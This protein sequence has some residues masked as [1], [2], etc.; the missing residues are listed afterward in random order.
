MV[1]RHQLLSQHSF[2][3]ILYLTPPVFMLDLI[4]KGSLMGQ[5]YEWQ[6][7]GSSPFH[8]LTQCAPNI[9]ALP[10]KPHLLRTKQIQGFCC[11]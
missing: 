4:L 2:K 7:R 10:V 3:D 6:Q 1:A 9:L 8:E 5:N 11:L